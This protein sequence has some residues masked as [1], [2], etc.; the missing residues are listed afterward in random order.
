MPAHTNCN[1]PALKSWISVNASSD[2]PIQNLPFGIFSRKNSQDPTSSHGGEKRAGVAIG[3]SI[4]DLSELFAHKLLNDCGLPEQNVFLQPTLNGFIA[5]GRPVWRAVRSRISELLTDSNATLRDNSAARSKAVVLASEATVHLPIFIPNYVDFY[6]SEEHATNV[7]MMFRDPTNPLL[8]NWKH[9]P[10]GY[11]GRSSTIYESGTNFCR[12]QGQLKADADPAPVFAPSR[13]LDF[14]LEVGFITGRENTFG[15]GVSV[16]EAD[17]YIFGLVLLNDWTARDIQRWEYVP[18]G[19][20]LSKTFFTSISPWI[21]TLDALEPFRTQGPAPTVPVLPY[22]EC[23]TPKALDLNLQV[24]LKP[25][26]QAEELCISKTNFKD[27]YWNMNQQLAHVT[28][29][30]C[31][32]CVGDVYGSGTVSGKTP[33]S[34]GSMLEICWKGTRPLDLPNGEKRTF[35]QDGDTVTMRGYASKNGVRVGF[36]EVTNTVLPAKTKA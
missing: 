17:G 35:I 23:H 1:N 10:I 18:L 2:F 12:P 19:P 33:D 25:A 31:K 7:G 32:L 3:E 8:P 4:V 30:G 16:E 21:V 9:I 5:L 11:N 36:G 6:S 15:D 14:E 13:Q 24:F 29:N 26:N 22:L 27:M 20:F 28:S 34:L